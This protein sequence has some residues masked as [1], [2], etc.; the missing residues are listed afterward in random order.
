MLHAGTAT[1]AP[2]VI[3][4]GLATLAVLVLAWMWA[5][6]PPRMGPA[7]WEDFERQFA[8]Y[9]AGGAGDAPQPTGE[10]H[11]RADERAAKKAGGRTRRPT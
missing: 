6:R 7:A 10:S 1:W 2:A 11:E 3:A 8:A 9:V 5:R 4:V